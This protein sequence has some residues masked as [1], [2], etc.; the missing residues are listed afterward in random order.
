MANL[1]LVALAL[2]TVASC[3]K[4]DS[5]VNQVIRLADRNYTFSNGVVPRNVLESYLSRSITQAEFLVSDGFFNA[6]PYPHR[7][8]DT[9]MLKDVGAKFVGRDIY[10][11]NVPE[12][13]NNPEFLGQ[14]EA[15][16]LEMQAFDPDIIFQAAI[17]EIVSTKVNVVPVPSWVF[18]AFD[19]P[20]EDRNFSYEQMLNPDGVLVNHWGVGASVPD[21]SQLETRMFFYYMA[22]RYM[23]AGIEALHFGQAELMAMTDRDNN[24]AAWR[25]LLQK[26]RSAASEL[27]RRGTV[28]C[29]AHLPNGGISVDGHLL[30][31]FVSFPL[32]L[33]EIPGDPRKS[34][35][36]IYYLD[37]IYGRTNGG[38]R[39]EESRV[40]KEGVSTCRSRCSPRHTNKK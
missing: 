16:I 33:K 10:S 15:R 18:A 38:I 2:I 35:L 30:F 6:G 8:D 32:R 23:E 1:T 12:P 24:Y 17:F 21:I 29:D 31:D 40:G 28:L 4:S 22:C 7:D 11:W 14:A 27:A 19:I 37:A 13:F 25:D 3:Q 36:K 34:E 26:V 5:P 20:A 39:S 9:R